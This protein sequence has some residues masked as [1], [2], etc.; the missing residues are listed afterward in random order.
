MD[1]GDGR[2]D[3]RKGGGGRGRGLGLGFY[4]YDLET[5]CIVRG[6]GALSHTIIAIAEIQKSCMNFVTRYR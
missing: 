6:G 3:E 2:G 1:R 5:E 4:V